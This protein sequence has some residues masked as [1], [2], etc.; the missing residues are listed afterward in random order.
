MFDDV[1]EQVPWHV[2]EQREYLRSQ[3]RVKS[4]HSH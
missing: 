1:Y 2:A 4:P 3:P